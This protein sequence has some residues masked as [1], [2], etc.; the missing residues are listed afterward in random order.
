MMGAQD[1]ERQIALY[2]NLSVYCAIAAV[3]LLVI[4]IFLFIWLKIP[5]VFNEITGRGARKAIEEMSAKSV[6]SG[7]LSS[8]KLTESGKRKRK[9]DKTDSLS[10]RRRYNYT[11]GLKNSDV[12]TNEQKNQFLKDNELLKLQ[13][14]NTETVPVYENQGMDDTTV[15]QQQENRNMNYR[16]NAGSESTGMLNAIGTEE[17]DVLI[18]TPES[19]DKSTVPEYVAPEADTMV[20]TSN[21]KQPDITFKMERSIIMIHTEEVIS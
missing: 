14:N 1:I 7:D 20:L 19:V 6:G 16:R 12:F 21:M 11:D 18:G 3:I 13:N 5:H 15:I 4:A 10:L 2:H 17:T 9:K 8:V